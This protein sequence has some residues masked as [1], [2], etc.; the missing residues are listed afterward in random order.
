MKA[1][2]PE[3]DLDGVS[4]TVGALWKQ[5]CGK[6]ILF[7]GA[8]GFFGSWMLETFLHANQTLGLGAKAVAV[9]R[10]G[11]QFAKQLPHL[12]SH[13][14]VEVLEADVASVPTPEGPVDFVIH[15][16]V[17]DTGTPLPETASFFQAA[18]QQLLDIALQKNASAFLLCSTG[19]VY[20]PKDPP[21][22]FSERDPLVPLDGPLSYRQIRRRVE[23]QCSQA[24]A[25]RRTALKIARGFTF[26]GPRLPLDGNFAVGNFLH[27]ALAGRTITV[28]GNGTPIR[29]YLYAADMAAWLWIILLKGSNRAS[30]NVGSGEAI[31]IGDLAKTIGTLFMQD[32]CIEGA[33][34]PGTAPSCYL[35]QI[36]SA[37]FPEKPISLPESLNRTTSWHQTSA[38]MQARP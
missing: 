12:A 2:L 26:V 17:P 27:D 13:P 5:L 20:Q 21:A 6:H 16:I 28:K 37:L 22:P 33:P 14:Q 7:T 38:S 34:V 4:R 10:S 1:N 23:E 15:S 24:L 8:S 9:T 11:M 31:T 19:A 32:V 3:G 35:P 30:Y 36:G 29:S 25:N 18:T